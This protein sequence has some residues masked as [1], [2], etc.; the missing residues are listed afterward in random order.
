MRMGVKIAN[1]MWENVLMKM[2]G[3]NI[4]RV[5]FCTY[6]DYLFFVPQCTLHFP[7]LVTGDNG[8]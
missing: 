3:F 8:K 7:K 1:V 2:K 6:V 4:V 5:E